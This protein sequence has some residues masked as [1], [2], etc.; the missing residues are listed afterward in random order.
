MT[1]EVK[2]TTVY[3]LGKSY[4]IKCGENDIVSLQEAADF[5][6]EKM[7]EI[8]KIAHVL[9]IDRVALLAALNMSHQLLTLQHE[10]KCLSENV[11]DRLSDLQTNLDKVLLPSNQMELSSSE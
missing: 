10:K 3:I 5:L 7:Q 2:G 11:N 1:I 9:S 6:E 4:Q 8:R